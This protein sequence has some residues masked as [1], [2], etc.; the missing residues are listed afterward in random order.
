MGA[1]AKNTLLM[2]AAGIVLRCVGLSYQV[3]LAE[4]IGQAGI[5][6]FQ[7]IGTV[8]MLCATLAISGIRFA[9]TRLVSEEI[10]LGRGDC[11]GS[12][13]GKCLIYACCF[14]AL[15]FAAMFFGSERI[16][17]LWIGDG[18]TVL[19]LKTLSI[20][21]PML[22]LSSVFSGFFIATGRVWQAS[23]IQII[24]QLVNIFSAFLLLEPGSDIEQSCAAIAQSNVIA[25]AT[26]MAL[27]ASV[28]FFVRPKN[29][30]NPDESALGR[31]MLRIALPLA[32]SAYARQLS[33]L[34]NKCFDYWCMHQNS[35]G[36]LSPPVIELIPS[37]IISSACFRASLTA[38]IT[39]SSRVSTSSGSTTSF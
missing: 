2:T 25:D 6:L 15:A 32:F 5:G 9:S 20:S 4:S 24:E 37:A 3:W 39:R 31:R 36:I 11:V 34:F 8:N 33:K 17:F 19:S 27:S 21:M 13:V 29:V 26:S 7:L 30:G 10:G 23:S 38:A 12:A 35:P 22:A 14:G 16:G 1:L 28:Y 18:R